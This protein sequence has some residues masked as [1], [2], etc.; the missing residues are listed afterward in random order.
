[1]K[2]IK[3]KS[4]NNK[5]SNIYGVCAVYSDD[6]TCAE[7]ENDAK[8]NPCPPR[9][10]TSPHT[11]ES[12]VC[13]DTDITYPSDFPKSF[14]AIP[15]KDVSDCGPVLTEEGTPDPNFHYHPGQYW[16]N[17]VCSKNW[18][19]LDLDEN[20]DGICMYYPVGSL[21]RDV[22]EYGEAWSLTWAFETMNNI[23]GNLN[24]YGIISKLRKVYI[25]FKNPFFLEQPLI[26]DRI[27]E[28]N[29]ETQEART[30]EP[31]KVDP[32]VP[33]L[34]D[35]YLSKTDSSQMCMA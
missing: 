27:V 24:Y 8:G 28:L 16:S 12:G 22:G 34:Y 1:M 11:S 17:P 7:W 30:I 26:P 5:H 19:N 3:V 9:Y 29:W 31:S 18:R 6:Y 25:R 32:D 33:W 20:N 23:I 35:N 2:S 21:D 14:C 13:I 15:C 10:P 4:I